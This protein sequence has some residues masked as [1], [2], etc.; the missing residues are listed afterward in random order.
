MGWMH[1]LL[2]MIF[3]HFVVSTQRRRSAW[4]GSLTS[5]NT[6]TSLL[7]SREAVLQCC[8][9][10]YSLAS[11]WKAWLYSMGAEHHLPLQSLKEK[12]FTRKR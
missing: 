4:L 7:K 3:S 6:G 8:Q 10:L 1:L 5:W 11:A 9:K 12:L 2:Q